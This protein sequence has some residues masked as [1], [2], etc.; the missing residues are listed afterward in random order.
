MGAWLSVQIRYFLDT[1]TNQGFLPDF[2]SAV[3]TARA[4]GDLPARDALF[5]HWLDHIED[6]LAAKSSAALTRYLRPRVWRTI[7]KFPVFRTSGPPYVAYLAYQLPSG[8]HRI[9]V[10]AACYQFGK[11]GETGWLNSVIA[12]RIATARRLR[13]V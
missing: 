1:A 11:G 13:V 2:A 9:F 12:P 7:D 10:L 8:A 4:A 6:S 3:R 5:S